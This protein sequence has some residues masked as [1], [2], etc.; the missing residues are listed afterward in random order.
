MTL[1]L[2]LTPQ[3]LYK[4]ALEFLE[5]ADAAPVLGRQRSALALAV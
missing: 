4:T 1:V 5:P 3:L 2:V